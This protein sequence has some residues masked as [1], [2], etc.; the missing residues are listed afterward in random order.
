MTNENHRL[1]TISDLAK[2][3]SVSPRQIYRLCHQ[4]KLPRPI[5]V[6]GAIRWDRRRIEKWIDELGTEEGEP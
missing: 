6:G 3:L 2:E 1:L 4:G 5:R